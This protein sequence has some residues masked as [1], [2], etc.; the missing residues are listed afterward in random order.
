MTRQTSRL[1]VFHH[2]KTAA[3]WRPRQL[4]LYFEQ[5]SGIIPGAW[6]DAMR[7]ESTTAMT[8]AWQMSIWAGCADYCMWNHHDI[9]QWSSSDSR[10]LENLHDIVNKLVWVVSFLFGCFNCLQATHYQSAFVAFCVCSHLQLI[11]LSIC[12]WCTLQFGTSLH[13]SDNCSSPLSGEPAFWMK[14]SVL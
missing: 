11:S 2:E 7:K 13:C 6:G 10:Q 14:W 4:S 9:Y 5:L 8:T 1:C 3:L 12:L